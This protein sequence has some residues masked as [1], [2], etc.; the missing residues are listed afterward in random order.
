MAIQTI[1][2]GTGELTGDG[3]SIRSAFDK[4]NNNFNELYTQDGSDVVLSAINASLIPDTDVA[5]DLGST[6]N[7]FRDLYL[8][9][10]TIDLGGTTISAVGGVLQVGGVGF[11]ELVNS[12]LADNRGFS[13]SQ[14]DGNGGTIAGAV[15][16]RSTEVEL[17]QS[18]D[19]AGTDNEMRATLRLTSG[20]ATLES[21]IQTLDGNNDPYTVFTTLQTSPG[22]LNIQVDG[23]SGTSDFTFDNSGLTLSKILSPVTGNLDLEVGREAGGT[24]N[25]TA[26]ADKSDP[27]NGWKQIVWGY[28]TDRYSF[29]VGGD[30]DAQGSINGTLTGNVAKVNEAFAV[31]V[32]V[33]GADP[34][35]YVWG[36]TNTYG[37]GTSL[38]I[39]RADAGF[40][41]TEAYGIATS[42]IQGP[43]IGDGVSDYAV[44][45]DIDSD[46]N[47]IILTVIDPESE[48]FAND[49]AYVLRIAETVTTVSNLLTFDLA[50]QLAVNGNIAGDNV[51]AGNT[52]FVGP[53]QFDANQTIS[54]GV[55]S[56]NG[57]G[58]DLVITS[59]FD[60]TSDVSGDIYLTTPD[61]E[62]NNNG[63]VIVGGIL[64]A[65]GIETGS[66]VSDSSLFITTAAD[67]SLQ[68]MAS[69]TI[70][71]VSSINSSLFWGWDN[72][73]ADF[74]LEVPGELK[75]S[76]TGGSGLS[77]RYTTEF[78]EF[79]G[80]SQLSIP[81]DG[82]RSQFA[83]D[84]V[85][86]ESVVTTVE[87]GSGDG[88]LVINAG[89]LVFT[90]TWSFWD[91]DN[92]VA[93]PV[94]NVTD[95]GGGFIEMTI[96][97]F[98][99]G[100]LAIGLDIV[101]LFDRETN[102]NPHEIRID[103]NGDATG[104]RSL[105]GAANITGPDND[106]LYL[107]TSTNDGNSGTISSNIVMTSVGGVKNTI[108]G[109]TDFGN[110]A[111]VD[112]T[113]ATV[114]G[115][116]PFDQDL[117]TTDS[118][119]F[120][121][122][123]LTLGEINVVPGTDFNL[124]TTPDGVTSHNLNFGTDGYLTID[125]QMYA[126]AY[127]LTGVGYVGYGGGDL[128]VASTTGNIKINPGDEGGSLFTFGTDGTLTLPGTVVASS[129]YPTPGTGSVGAVSAMI[130][131]NGPNLNWTSTGIFANG[132]NFVFSVDGSG[133]ATVPTITDGGTSHFVGETFTV[134]GT[135]LGLSSPADDVDFQ[136]TAIDPG[137]PTA[138]DLSKQVQIITA[139]GSNRYYTL[140]DGVEG[141]IMHFVPNS[142]IDTDV[143]IRI[144]NARIVDVGGTGLPVA[145]TNYSWA[146]FTVT[147]APRTISTAIFAD[148]AWCLQ[149]GSTD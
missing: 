101:Q 17:F 25:V 140:A 93:Y 15:G 143:Y 73:R 50:G 26:W 133:N 24:F 99:F 27:G 39:P 18:I 11:N 85:G 148:G 56:N 98:D 30:I 86:K 64:N 123:G 37:S 121:R 34:T 102:T 43:G 12:T 5:Y 8:S 40:V 81:L 3:E 46:P 111:T 90:T 28:D 106:F 42:T 135:A 53:N 145:A 70:S 48:S 31:S 97:G 66:I 146:V 122:V 96:P 77:T 109:T 115:F 2:L 47:N 120:D 45:V 68:I 139:T 138:L 104:I 137:S 130:V 125:G 131:T 32:D 35:P 88:K 136:V 92:G 107:L 87:T 51:I 29:F 82:P 114:T 13:A 127:N 59:G 80:A 105:T 147:E 118:P 62:F 117:N 108:N 36:F 149:G 78:I 44:S 60:A 57:L 126:N 23:G 112:F 83:I 61:P 71:E 100:T 79:Q 113:N 20:E 74:T 95:L 119:Q 6:T 69:H 132:I 144:A 19:P 142:T 22:T 141:Q 49:V 91:A 129:V 14:D 67:N 55:N 75:V 65:G 52:V 38:T 7:R 89:S 16:V 21:T 84:I 76:D 9:G 58:I 124:Y 4:I 1:N 103:S 63:K 134:P 72:A 33:T 10:S 110:G 94:T 41:L 128:F 116:N 54:Y